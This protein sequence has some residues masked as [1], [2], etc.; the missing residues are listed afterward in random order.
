VGSIQDV[1]VMGVSDEDEI[2][3]LNVSID[4]SYVGRRDVAPPIRPAGISRD[5]VAS[6]RWWSV[7]PREIGI[8]ED[9]RGSIGDIQPAAPKYFR[10]TW[11]LFAVV[12]WF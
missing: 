5:G 11:L 4:D 10:I 8:D 2:C 6:R 1:V 9:R 7:N 3:P 12:R